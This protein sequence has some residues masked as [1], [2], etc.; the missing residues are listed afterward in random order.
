MKCPRCGNELD[1]TKGACASCGYV[2]RLTG[3]PGEPTLSAPG[4][5]QQANGP[6]SQLLIQ[7]QPS[8]DLP[9]PWR[10]PAA[11]TP[12]VRQQS[13]G[14]L[15]N[16]WRQSGPLPPATQQSG[17][18]PNP[19]RQATDSLSLRRQSGGLPEQMQQ[20]G[21]LSSIRKQS[22]ELPVSR[23]RVEPTLPLKQQA[24]QPQGSSLGHNVTPPVTQQ[25]GPLPLLPLPGRDAQQMST[26]HP[27]VV[28]QSRP[29]SSARTLVKP[30]TQP[31]NIGPL[32][33][34]V[35][36]RGGRYRLQEM[37]KC[38]NWASGVFEVTWIGKDSQR[39]GS[40]VMICEV[41]LPQSPSATT[42]AILRKAT[43]TLVS[44][45]RHPHI[46][47]LW[48]AFSDQG[49][50]FFVFEPIE[51]ESLYVRMRRGGRAIAEDEVIECCLQMTEVLD[52]LAQQSPPVVHGLIQPEYIIQGRNSSQFV[53]TNFSVVL[54][55]GAAQFV[56]GTDRSQLSPYTAP[57]FVRG[58]I[59]VRSDMYSLLAVAYHAVTGNVPGTISGSVSPAKQINKN[60]SVAFDAILT[61]GLRTVAG[62]RYQRPSDLRQDLLAMRSASGPLVVGS[63]SADAATRTAGNALSSI[64][65]R[66]GVRT[67]SGPQRVPNPVAGAR[68]I[69]QA[70]KADDKEKQ[71][72]LLHQESLPPVKERND[73][74]NVSVL[75]GLLIIALIVLA[76][77]S[78]IHH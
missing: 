49:R 31:L 57:E 54:A 59:D 48:D 76:V 38:Q 44:I 8:G 37:V 66:N 32:L 77:I 63:S 43:M 74:R 1:A 15:P 7:K 52:L 34:G 4:P 61:K 23:Q 30:S 29:N 60:V 53:L 24:V 5:F 50:S 55:G 16:P 72:L 28:A 14:D 78:Q 20:A 51:G 42:Q 73:M 35:L 67:S 56:A 27:A 12:P 46:P 2:I 9:N 25:S 62:Q 33:P 13:S 69:V 36:L 19:W 6:S 22:G 58:G 45:G 75:L 39:G 71:F 41:V 17:D 26:P 64:D 11:G 3:R 21:G 18:L 70:P 40:Q 65:T 68:P 10:R 47:A